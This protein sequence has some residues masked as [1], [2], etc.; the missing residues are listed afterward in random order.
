MNFNI[1]KK[2]LLF[3]VFEL[4]F[5]MSERNSIID[6]IFKEF[7][8]SGYDMLREI[9]IDYQNHK[10]CSI[11]VQDT[12]V[13]IKKVKEELSVPINIKDTEEYK[14][15]QKEINILKHEKNL[16]DN[17]EISKLI[18]Q[19][20]IL[21][22]SNK[23]FILKIEEMQ[24]IHKK[25]I[26]KLKSEYEGKIKEKENLLPTPSNSNEIKNI[27]ERSKN[28]FE[29]KNLTILER[30]NVKVYNYNNLK[31][32]SNEL[33]ILNYIS[34]ENKVLIR[35]YSS[36]TEKFNINDDT[37]WKKIYNFKVNNGELADYP[38]NKKRFKYKYIR[39]KQLYNKYGENLKRFSMSIHYLG[40]LTQ[41][42]WNLFLKE[43][44][45]LYNDTFKNMKPCQHKYKDNKIC[46]IFN[47]N[48]K[49]KNNI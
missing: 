38:N 6:T 46:G 5:I 48:K 24:N 26:E 22:S 31:C 8:I 42:E 11:P 4:Q 15:L 28:K 20:N 7:D 19:I 9:L 32:N 30:C 2:S 25:E 21:T 10:C 3:I 43:F 37:I 34:S 23:N 47:C 49:H 45:K 33:N 41:N 44:D 36:I 29:N 17:N 40:I 13:K 14:L 16:Y 27:P 1:N 12:P 39:C 18:E 35:F